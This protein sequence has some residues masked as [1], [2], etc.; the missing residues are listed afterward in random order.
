[1]ATHLFTNKKTKQRI[2]MRSF[3]IAG[4]IGIVF[5]APIIIYT[6]Q[7]GFGIWNEHSKWA[8]MGSALSGI[9][10]PIIAALA[11]YILIIQ[12]RS[13]NRMN[14][15]QTQMHKNQNEMYKHQ[16]DQD[17][18]NRNEDSTHFYINELKHLLN[19]QTSLEKPVSEFVNQFSGIPEAELR[20]SQNVALSKLFISNHKNIFYLWSAITNGLVGLKSQSDVAYKSSYTSLLLRINTIITHES[21]LALDKLFYSSQDIDKDNLHFLSRI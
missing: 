1:M 13:Q 17:F 3:V 11:S 14:S 18:I 10:S 5:C 12:T 8:E 9:Y 21:C 19:Q 7:F 6:Y 15:Y 16:Y 2:D 20:S 4:L